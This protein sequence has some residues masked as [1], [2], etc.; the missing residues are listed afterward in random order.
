MNRQDAERII[1]EYLKP[2]FGFALKRCKSE[3]DAEDLSQEIVLRA[4]RALLI[5]NDIADVGKFIWTVAH[6]TL[7]NYYRDCAKSTVGVSLDEVAEVIADPYSEDEVREEAE[8][9]HRLQSEIAYLSKLQ[10]RIL[11]AYYF[12]N[13]K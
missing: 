4:F 6:N 10:R 5:K 12:E 7:S 1:T 13:R 2:I 11:I 9:V 8:T 3:Q